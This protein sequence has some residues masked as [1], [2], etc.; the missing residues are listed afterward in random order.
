MAKGTI[1]VSAQKT[2]NQD[3]GAGKIF[4]QGWSTPETTISPS[5]Y[6]GHSSAINISEG[7][8]T[9]LETE[10]T[11]NSTMDIQL[12]FSGDDNWHTVAKL[13]GGTT[14]GHKTQRAFSFTAD[15]TTK[16]LL[17]KARV[18][19]I[20][21]VGTGGRWDWNSASDVSITFTIE[22]DYKPSGITLSN[23]TVDIGST[24]DFTIVNSNPTSLHHVIKFSLAN[25]GETTQ[26][27][28]VGVTS[29]SFTVPSA[30]L[31]QLPNS[32]FGTAILTIETYCDAL[33]DETHISDKYI[34]VKTQQFTAAVATSVVPTIGS[35]TVSVYNGLSAFPG[36]Y[37]KT[38]TGAT[39]KINNSAAPEH[40]TL[41]EF[42]LTTSS[43][44]TSSYSSSNTTFTI[45]EFAGSGEI[46][47][48]VVAIDSRGRS[49]VPQ[50]ATIYVHP[51][52]K[53]TVQAASAFRS[54]ANGVA[55]INGTSATTRIVARCASI[56]DD[57][58]NELN[59][60][61]ITGQYYKQN[62]STK[63]D[64]P[65][66]ANPVKS[67]VNYTVGNDQMAV[68][69]TYYIT[70]TLIDT[71]T[72]SLPTNRRAK[73]I[74]TKTIKVETAS[75]AI[76]VRF[77]GD[78]VAFGKTSEQAQAVEINPD[79]D[80]YYKNVE[81]CPLIFRQSLPSTEGQDVALQEGMV[82]IVPRA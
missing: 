26:S 52:S 16:N 34:G 3:G 2:T 46:T 80:L 17:G 29:G 43:G 82:C 56:Q 20:R 55:A 54:T 14:D 77:G 74:T 47:L 49:S 27:V 21:A 36:K 65:S 41:R 68:S 15:D 66:S 37:F 33:G 11:T 70:F 69:D 53:P 67:G 8:V 23:E 58:G 5:R 48:Q 9:N 31:A 19:G 42:K 76:H 81:V 44:E 1:T 79:W 78:G 75:Y 73:Y 10:D 45:S 22:T 28:A 12:K 6:F 72:A 61:T 64:F 71:I 13:T 30:W 59:T 18:T 38:L 40:T 60:L 7:Y 25:S 32:T 63:T 62:A 57:N 39:I 24:V 4:D 51:Y 35:I 50:T